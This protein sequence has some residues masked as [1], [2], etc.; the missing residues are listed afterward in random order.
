LFTIALTASLLLCLAA[1]VLWAGTHSD[2][3]RTR[4]LGAHAVWI[5]GSGA[6]LVRITYMSR[7]PREPPAQR[8]DESGG[9]A[10]LRYTLGDIEPET[11]RLGFG[12]V[13]TDD[14][15]DLDLI[16][17]AASRLTLI[18]VPHWFVVGVAAVLPLVWISGWSRT[19]MRRAHG[20]CVDCRYDLRATPDRCPECGAA[21]TTGAEP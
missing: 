10:T 12:F 13:T 4:H 6:G 20:C 7:S 9:D 19:R 17:P 14:R 2:G 1:C 21:A 18:V 15:H 16:A 8:L 3:K 11:D 5:V